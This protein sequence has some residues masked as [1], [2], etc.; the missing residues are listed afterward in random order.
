MKKTDPPVIVKQIFHSPIETVWKSITELEKMHQWYFENIP[1]FKPEVGFKTQFNIQSGERN[2]L[3]K[4]EVLEVIPNKLIKYNWKYEAYPGDSNVKFELFD[5]NNNTK[6]VL[7]VN[8]LEDFP[9]DI[10]EFKRESC[11]GGWEYLIKDRL[12]N[13]LER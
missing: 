8:I 11:I 4:W 1:S 5:E 3:H 2:F 10:P 6:L 9:Q 7:T 12:K 13:Y